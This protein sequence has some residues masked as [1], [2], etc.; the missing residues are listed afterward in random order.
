MNLRVSAGIQQSRPQITQR[1]A[2][3]FEP[4]LTSWTLPLQW[5]AVRRRN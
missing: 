4:K 2:A 1:V 3:M 5:V